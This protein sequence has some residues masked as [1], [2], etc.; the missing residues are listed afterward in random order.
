MH[1]LHLNLASVLLLYNFQDSD[2]SSVDVIPDSEDVVSPIENDNGAAAAQFYKSKTVKGFSWGGGAA[3]VPR[4]RLL[5]PLQAIF[6]S[7]NMLFQ[8]V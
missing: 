3:A 2:C 7:W 6:V 8:P 5:N 4:K 1:P